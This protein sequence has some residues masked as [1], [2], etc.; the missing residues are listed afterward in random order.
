[1]PVRPSSTISSGPPQRVAITGTPQADASR[2]V[3]EKDSDRDRFRA[4][5][6]PSRADRGD[7]AK[8]PKETA[9]DT[10][11][12]SACRFRAARYSRFFRSP[13]SPP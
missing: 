6:A 7:G 4:A 8:S 2:T 9:S 13:M 3:R 10:P 5:K 11:S 12:S 1:M